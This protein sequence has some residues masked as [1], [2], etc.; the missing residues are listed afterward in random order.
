MTSASVKAD[1]RDIPH[2]VAVG[3][4]CDKRGARYESGQGTVFFIGAPQEGQLP[5]DSSTRSGIP[6]GQS[7]VAVRELLA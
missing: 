5:D 4:D 7:T 3:D 1:G 2:S 6:D